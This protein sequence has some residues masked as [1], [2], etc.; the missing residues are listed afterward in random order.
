MCGLGWCVF[1]GCAYTASPRGSSGERRGGSCAL[2]SDASSPEGQV[3]LLPLL[4][5]LGPQVSQGLVITPS[6]PEIVLNVSSTFVLTCS[7]PAPV[8]W[9]RMMPKQLPQEL[10]ETPDGNF[11]SVLTLTNVNGSDTGEYFC[12]YNDSHGL[13]DGE[14]KR[15]YIFVPGKTPDLCAHSLAPLLNCR[16]LGKLRECLS[17]IVKY[18]Q[19]KNADKSLNPAWLSPGVSLPPFG[20]NIYLLPASPPH[21]WLPRT[22]HSQLVPKRSLLASIPHRS[23]PP[24]SAYQLP[25]DLRLIF[26]PTL[27]LSKSNV[28]AKRHLRD[29]PYCVMG[30]PR[31]RK[32]KRT[33]QGH[34]VIREMARNP[35]LPHSHSCPSL[36]RSQH[37]LSPCVP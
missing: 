33:A 25:F 3:L 12:T 23:H 37:G 8:M 26:F 34:T 20:L 24:S 13:E 5:L 21:S 6:E 11:S 28:K 29:H 7:G 10:T 30:R 32:G 9:K 14:Q 27:V 19:L 17:D 4:V 36:G 16:H 18:G 1:K 31:A 2:T 35:A 22:L 15:L